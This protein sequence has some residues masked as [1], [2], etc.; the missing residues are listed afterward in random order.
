MNSAELPIEID[1]H[2]VKQMRDEGHPFVLLDCREQSE[3][4]LV[5]IE[6]ATLVPM[7]EI[8][9]RV[10]ELEAYRDKHIVV[11]C[12]HGGRSLQVTHWLRRQQF[13]RVQ[14]MTGGIDAWSVA[15]DPELPR[16]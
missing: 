3:Y 6:G 2:T 13:P 11:Y 1:V 8:T 15:I 10:A 14:N 4:E 16:Y 5:R 7:S 12:H 9:Q